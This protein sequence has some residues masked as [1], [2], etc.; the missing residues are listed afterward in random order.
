MCI[1]MYVYTAVLLTALHESNSQ[2]HRRPQLQHLTVLASHDDVCPGGV[3]CGD[4]R[5]GAEEG[6]GC[7]V[8]VL[9]VSVLRVALALENAEDVALGRD[10]VASD[11]LLTA[12]SLRKREPAARQ[13]PGELLTLLRLPT[14]H[15]PVACRAV[16]AA[17]DKRPAGVNE[18]YLSHCKTA[19]TDI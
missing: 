7:F 3:D 19:N 8:F 16:P 14:L 6:D 2:E 17:R 13:P 4:C 12:V 5:R 11:L 15:V 9:C 10:S 18:L 1:H